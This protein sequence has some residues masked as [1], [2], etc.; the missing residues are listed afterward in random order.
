MSIKARYIGIGFLVIIVLEILSLYKVYNNSLQ[1]ARDI[2][3]LISEANVPLDNVREHITCVGDISTEVI[4]NIVVTTHTVDGVTYYIDHTE[5]LLYA[6]SHDV[7]FLLILGIIYTLLFGR[8]R[9]IDTERKKLTYQLDK[10][11][12]SVLEKINLAVVIHHE[13]SLPV[14][15]INSVIESMEYR[16][17]LDPDPEYTKYI[18]LLK[19]NI[20]SIS[21]VLDRMVAGKEHI[22]T[23]NSSIKTLIERTND[24]ISVYYIDNNYEFILENADILDAY[25]PYKLS[26][27]TFSNIINNLIKNSLEAM[28]TKIVFTCNRQL[29]KDGTLTLIIQDNGHGIPGK[30]LSEINNKIFKP[31]VSSKEVSL[32]DRVKA[33]DSGIRDN[34]VRGTGL[35]LCKTILNEV[36]GDITIL[37]TSYLGTTFGI[38]LRV[39]KL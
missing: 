23:A 15:V 38:I 1:G 36:G 22:G 6:L 30:S 35:Y 18:A 4:D 33:L 21:S 16:N 25:T 37:D 8:M 39:R 2:L 10:H 27:G 5:Q 34:C 14:G 20:L 28:A 3:Y 7:V 12:L 24:S 19:S 31:G 9:I 11:D 13:M 26:D 17:S 29:N 32:V